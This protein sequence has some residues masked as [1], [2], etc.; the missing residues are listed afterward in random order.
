MMSKRVAMAI[1]DRDSTIA[2]LT[3]EN[4]K[5]KVSKKF[6][7]KA[8]DALFYV[9][10]N[11]TDAEGNGDDCVTMAIDKVRLVEEVLIDFIKK[12]RA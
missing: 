10:F 5:L 12:H 6:L 2:K 4:R 3:K 9:A 11:L 1:E 8:E 7:A